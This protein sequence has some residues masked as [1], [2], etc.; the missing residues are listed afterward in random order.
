MAKQSDYYDFDEQDEE[1]SE[2]RAPSPRPQRRRRD[3]IAGRSQS[4]AKT[5]SGTVRQIVQHKV[6]PRDVRVWS[7]NPRFQQNLQ[8]DGPDESALIESIKAEG[9]RTPVVARRLPNDDPQ[10]FE[11]ISG[12]RRFFAV[13]YLREHNF[14]EIKLLL[15]VHDLTDEEAFREADRE[16][17]CRKDVS[18]IERALHYTEA[19]GL[20]YDGH[21]R[22][23][24]ERTGISP[25]NISK[26]VKIGT[27]PMAI[28]EAFPD[29]SQISQRLAYAIAT[30]I[31]DEEIRGL[32]LTNAS[33]IKSRIEAGETLSDQTVMKLLLSTGAKPGKASPTDT[34]LYSARS[35][36]SRPLIDVK[37]ATK[38]GITLKLHSNSGATKEE[39]LESLTSALQHHGILP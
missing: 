29:I 28:W 33:S 17:R 16:N 13:S 14:P 12:S 2:S 35:A 20:Y 37:A 31:D 39:I 8:P 9:Q 32:A 7:G 5:I 18:T 34:N 1:A 38:G 22:A 36:S 26:Y 24:A 27:V 4:V 25:A 19:I 15:N 6:D 23:M 11:I 21:T 3:T 10:K 30:A